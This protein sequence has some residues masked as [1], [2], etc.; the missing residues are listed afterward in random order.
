LNDTAVTQV[1]KRNVVALSLMTFCYA[2]FQGMCQSLVPLSMAHLSFTKTTIGFY[3]GSLCAVAGLIASRL[4]SPS[5][6]IE[7][8]VGAFEFVAGAY[9][10]LFHV[11]TRQ[12]IVLLG[13]GFVSMNCF[14]L[15]VM[16][17]LFYLLYASQIG[18][19]AFVAAALISGRDAIGI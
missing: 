3:A 14:L 11:I 12:P 18:L 19:S 8:R 10:R 2:A 7:P 13:M 15:Y 16:G 17:G 5:R 4:I 6:A 1:F 9:V